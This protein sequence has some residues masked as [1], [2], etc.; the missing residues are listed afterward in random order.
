MDHP[1]LTRSNF[2]E[3]SAN[4]VQIKKWGTELLT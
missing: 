4:G 3:K 1:D 2:I